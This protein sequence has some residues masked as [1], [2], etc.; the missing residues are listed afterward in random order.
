MPTLDPDQLRR[1]RDLAGA[2]SPLG[3]RPAA[4]TDRLREDLGYD[5]LATVE[6]AAA[7]EQEFGI[8]A[9]D[10]ESAMDVETVADLVDLVQR[11]AAP[12]AAPGQH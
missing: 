10:E 8:D 11:S 5:S 1:I 12:A 7:L 6:L 2:M 3:P 9:I 4:A